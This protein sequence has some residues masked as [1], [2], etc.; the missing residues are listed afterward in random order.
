MAAQIDKE[1]TITNLTD[2][3]KTGPTQ[4]AIDGQYYVS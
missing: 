2:H 3:W 4:V 1:L